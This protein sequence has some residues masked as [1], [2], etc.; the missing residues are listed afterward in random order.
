MQKMLQVLM[1][2]NPNTKPWDHCNVSRF[3]PI[4][5]VWLVGATPTLTQLIPQLS[6]HMHTSVILGHGVNLLGFPPPTPCPLLTTTGT[7]HCQPLPSQG[8]RMAATFDVVPDGM[9]G[10]GFPESMLALRN[11]P[12]KLSNLDEVM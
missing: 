4:C 8:S 11:K 12:E 6:P 5:P 1:A 10:K 2:W 3:I 7:T 9:Q